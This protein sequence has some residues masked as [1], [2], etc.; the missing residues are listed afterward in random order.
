M[1]SELPKLF[2]RD[3]AIGFFLPAA[4]LA[5]WVY[6]IVYEF[7]LITNAPNFDTWGSSAW[8]IAIVWILAITLMALNYPI[9]RVLEGYGDWHPLKSWDSAQRKYFAKNVAPTLETQRRIDEARAAGQDPDVSYKHSR[10]LRIAVESYPDSSE[11]ILP[12]RFG[13]VFRALEVYPRVVYGIDAIPA[14]PRLQA[15]IPEHFNALISAAKAQLDFCVNLIATSAFTLI[16]YIALATWARHFPSLWVPCSA[17]GVMIL[18]YFLTITS[19]NRYGIY[20]KSAFDLFRGELAKQLGL[21]LPRSAQQEQ[22]MW[23][24]VSRVMIFRSKFQA[25]RLT[26]YKPHGREK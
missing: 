25:E 9:L 7:G 17:V 4:A 8:A 2:D 5:L 21:E 23:L 3:F 11:F 19:V 6:T 10:Q 20:V 24:T 13:N 16:L 15:V 14:W 26:R 12:T 18:S 1:F 22:E